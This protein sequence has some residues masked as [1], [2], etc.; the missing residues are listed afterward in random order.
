M[1]IRL[2]ATII[3]LAKQGKAAKA[4]K[5]LEQINAVADARV[6]HETVMLGGGGDFSL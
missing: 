1:L 5:L 6:S 3:K 4:A 2:M